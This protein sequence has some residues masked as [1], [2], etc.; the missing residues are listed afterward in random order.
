MLAAKGRKPRASRI[1]E[2][3][4]ESLDQSIQ[5]YGM[6]LASLPRENLENR[7]MVDLLSRNPSP[8]LIGW[9]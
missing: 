5:D 4:P 3:V 7:P 6:V 1:V 8:V 2:A 9:H